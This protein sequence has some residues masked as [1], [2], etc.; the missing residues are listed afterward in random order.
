MSNFA[1]R[2]PGGCLKAAS[3]PAKT[4]LKFFRKIP[5]RPAEVALM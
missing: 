4:D 5:M 1:L 2:K 3:G